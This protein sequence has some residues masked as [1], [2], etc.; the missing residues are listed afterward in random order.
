MTLSSIVMLVF[1]VFALVPKRRQ[2]FHIPNSPLRTIGSRLRFARRHGQ[3]KNR[4]SRL[5][6]P[7]ERRR[8]RHPHF[9]AGQSRIRQVTVIHC[10]DFLGNLNSGSKNLFLNFGTLSGMTN[11][12]FQPQPPCSRPCPEREVRKGALSIPSL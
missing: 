3:S 9:Q 7:L 5:A 12:S 11:Y 1:E 8:F 2:S 6:C 10:V 4:L